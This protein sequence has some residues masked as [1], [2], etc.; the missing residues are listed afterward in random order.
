MRAWRKGRHLTTWSWTGVRFVTATV[1]IL[2]TSGVLPGSVGAAAPALEW[3]AGA[4]DP[5]FASGGVLIA[6]FANPPGPQEG[7]DAVIQ[8]DGKIVVLTTSAYTSYLSRYLPDGE[9]DATFGNGGS[10]ALPSPGHNRYS[11]LTL[12]AQGRM[13]VIGMEPTTPWQAPDKSLQLNRSFNG[14]VYRFL[15]N[16]LPDSSFGTNGKTVIAV[17]PPEG[18]TPGSAATYPSAVLATSDGSIT[19]GGGVSSVC[20]WEVG[21]EFA[22]FWEESGTFVARLGPDGSLES[23]FGSSGLVS[24][25][26]Q[27]KHE[28]GAA[29]EGFGGLAQ[30]SPETVLA[31]SDHP[32]DNTWRFRTYSSTGALSEV[33][34]PAEGRSP[35]QVAV[36]PGHDLLVGVSGTEVLRRFNAQ[37][38][39]DTTFGTNG[40]ITILSMSCESYTGCFSVMPDGHIVVAGIIFAP[41]PRVGIRRY[42]VDGSPDDSFGAPPWLGGGSYS[43][44]Q[45]TPEADEVFVN[46]LL[47]SDGK[48]L[49]IGGAIVHKSGSPYPQTALA[50]FQADGGF[51]SNPPPL[52]PEEGPFSPITPSPGEGSRNSGAG[53]TSSTGMA[54]SGGSSSANGTGTGS[55]PSGHPGAS[56][57][58][59]TQAQ[60]LTKA[61]TACRKLKKGKRVKCIVAAKKRYKPKPRKRAKSKKKG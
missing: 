50:L 1:L 28:S 57:M 20:Y 12:D 33:Q 30:S 21:F 58:P 53:L 47:I 54:R 55:M 56:V 19:V 27:C 9:S 42:L 34:A 15:A 45:L 7:R 11:A 16:G 40:I 51:S 46:K 26:G 2:L 13:V 4:L 8:P 3:P 24:T 59:L 36:L 18:L 32:E 10:V 44:A 6:P 25:H 23:Q 5:G 61:I 17:P 22:Q 49:V 43:L 41:Y 38:M 14:V 52:N 31:L 48:P 37:G 35:G 39:P 29:P 60:K